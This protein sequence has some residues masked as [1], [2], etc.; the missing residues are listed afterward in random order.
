MHNMP[1]LESILLQ[2]PSRCSPLCV[3]GLGRELRTTAMLQLEVQL[4]AFAGPGNTTPGKDCVARAGLKPLLR[5]HL[6]AFQDERMAALLRRRSL[7]EKEKV[8][9][10][11]KKTKES[12]N[13]EG[14][15]FLIIRLVISLLNVSFVLFFSCYKQVTALFYEERDRVKKPEVN[16]IFNNIEYNIQY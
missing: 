2:Q 12:K 3:G 4:R 14:E 1:T 5:M 16:T 9:V 6:N 15:L 11:V 7:N 13:K 10:K 8:K